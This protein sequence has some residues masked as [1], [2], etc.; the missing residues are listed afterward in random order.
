MIIYGKFLYIELEER[1]MAMKKL[2]LNG[3][4][5]KGVS[6]LL[7]LSAMLG[8]CGG[9]VWELLYRFPDPSR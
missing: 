1:L 7:C 4:Y 3:L 6:V 5:K 2:L 9:A 8:A